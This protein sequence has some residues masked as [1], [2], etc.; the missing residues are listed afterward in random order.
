MFHTKQYLSFVK[1]G[2]FVQE[3]V[4][5]RFFFKKSSKVM[6]FTVN[7]LHPLGHCKLFSGKRA[8]CMVV[9]LVSGLIGAFSGGRLL[10]HLRCFLKKETLNRQG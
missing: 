8:H 4:E 5:Q 1:R 10:G 3:G 7:H 2:K 9:V 6:L